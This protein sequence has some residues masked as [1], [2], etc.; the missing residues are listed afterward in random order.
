MCVL[1]LGAT[2][3]TKAVHEYSKTTSYTYNGLKIMTKPG[4][5]ERLPHESLPPWHLSPIYGVVRHD[6]SHL[7]AS[8]HH[9]LVPRHA[10]HV[11][12]SSPAHAVL[13]RRHACSVSRT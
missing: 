13:A 6:Q 1:F 9:A 7:F 11:E 2:T 5:Y 3:S 12:E 4:I 8:V 10:W